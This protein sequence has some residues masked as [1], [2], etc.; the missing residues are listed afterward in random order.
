M[1]R[2]KEG[3]GRGSPLKGIF[4]IFRMFL[5]LI[6][7]GILFLG[8]YQAYIS[9]A[10]S[11]KPDKS[12]SALELITN[13]QLIFYNFLSSEAAYELINGLLTADPSKSIDKAKELLQ[14]NNSNQLNSAVKYKFAVLTDSHN[15]NANLQKALKQS[16]EAGAQFII[17]LGDYSDV[18]TIEELSN[19][20]REFDAVR[21]TYYSTV[22]DHDLWESRDKQLSATQNFSDTFGATYNSFSYHGDRFILIY[23]SD[24]YLG[25]DGVQ[26]NWLEQEL[27]KIPEEGYQN[28]FVFLSIPL[29][30]PSSDHVMGKIEP[31][32]KNQAEHLISLFKKAEVNLVVA[33]DTHVYSSYTE[34]NSLLPMVTSGALT[35]IRNVQ[36][37]RYLL[38]DVYEDGSYNVQDTEIR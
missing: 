14:E 36:A 3:Y 24:N 15:D 23:N 17:G 22:G 4:S 12:F 26:L 29:Y 34:P 27:A 25:I 31:K 10:N 33:G 7:M 37:P 21:L 8:V 30:H 28:V 2:Y 1:S 20:K 32:L 38:I 35:S 6:I 16:K 18:G 19:A 5:S 11:G 9:F 13:P